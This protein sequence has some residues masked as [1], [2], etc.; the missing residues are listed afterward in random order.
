MVD[1]ADEIWD[2][3]DRT[4]NYR[5]VDLITHPAEEWL[6]G[7]YRVVKDG[8]DRA[9]D[10]RRVHSKAEK[11]VGFNKVWQRRA[12]ACPDCHLPTLGSWLGE[13]MILCTNGDCLSQF[14][15][16]AYEELCVE[17]SRNQKGK[18]RNA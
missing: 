13:D 17:Q 11:M 6:I 7:G 14:T 15:R 9:L 4:A 5:I 3:I 16:T 1:M 18:K 12:A 2:A 8:V 10:I